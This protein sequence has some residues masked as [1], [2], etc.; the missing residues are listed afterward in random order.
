MTETILEKDTINVVIGDDHSFNCTA[1]TIGRTGEHSVSQLEI[2]IPAELNAF[3]AYLDFKKPK[4]ETISTGKLDIVNNKIEYDI[5]SGLLDE[6]GNLEV[7]LV[8]R[9]ENGEVWKSATKKFVVLKSIDAVDDIPEKEDFIIE[10]QKALEETKA[11]AY[12]NAPAIVETAVGNPIGISDVSAYEHEM[13]VKLSAPPPEKTDR[14]LYGGGE[15]DNNLQDYGFY[16][17]DTV[18]I[19]NDEDYGDCAIVT[20][21]EKNNYGEKCFWKDDTGT[22]D[23]KGLKKGDVVYFGESEASE[24]GALYRCRVVSVDGATVQKYGKNI[25]NPSGLLRVE[26]NGDII[27]K[28]E[29]DGSFTVTHVGTN[30]SS[31]Y[32]PVNVPAGVPVTLSIRG[33]NG[34]ASARFQVMQ[35]TGSSATPSAV[36]SSKNN[37]Y[38]YTYANPNG[39]TGAKVLLQGTIAGDYMNF[40]GFQVEIGTLATDFEAY[41]DPEPITAEADGTVNGIVGNGEGVSLFADNGITISAQYN[42]DTKKYIDKRLTMLAT[43]SAST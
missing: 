21:D 43:A 26:S 13:K 7:Q 36:F 39:I 30:Y 42:A 8:L 33:I 40:R 12:G 2:E 24:W 17:V 27:C 32:A 4:G 31:N 23:T 6:N 15:A 16:T 5:P 28:K 29:D 19:V 18:G 10:A 41:K 14:V 1:V 25:L 20:F 11:I 34:T 9:N 38:S 22:G 35:K 3:W 37:E